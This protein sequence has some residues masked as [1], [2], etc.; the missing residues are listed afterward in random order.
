MTLAGAGAAGAAAGP[1]PLG[2]ANPFTGTKASQPDFGT[3]GAAG[4]TFPGAVV[5]F[6]ALAWSPDTH[7]SRGNFAAG[8]TYSD[9]SIEGFSLTRLSGAG[10]PQLQDFPFM[11]TREPV[12]ASPARR[13]GRGLRSRYRARFSHRSES[14]QPGTYTVV[15]DPGTRK[16]IGVE[17]TAAPHSGVARFGFAGRGPANLL[18]DA[19]GSATPN[20]LA[21]VTIDPRRREISGTTRAG[22]FCGQQN[23]YEVHFVAR[24]DHGFDSGATWRGN[25]FNRGDLSAE[26][27]GRGAQAGAYVGFGRGVGTVE[28]RV[29]IS[30]TS[31]AA[32]RANLRAEVGGKSFEPV[33][34][35]ARRAWRKALG[36]VSV[37]GGGAGAQR[38][39]ATALYH[40]LLHPSTISD[41]AGTFPRY[42]GGVGR[43]RKRDRYSQISGWDVYRT[44][45]PL[46]ALLEPRLTS[47]VVRSLLGAAEESGALPK[48]PVA[49]GHT[50]VMTGDPAD[51]IIAGA[52]AMGARDFDVGAA[53]ART[54]EGATKPLVLDGGYSQRPG[55]AE[56]QALGYVPFELNADP[57][58]AVPAPHVLAWG[59][60]AT[61]LEYALADFSISCL[62]EAAG[63]APLRARF[64]A[65]SAAWENALDPATGLMAPRRS[66]GTFAGGD[67]TSDVGFA[68]GSAAQYTWMAP[69]DLPG[70][71]AAL[72]GSAVA[73]ARLDDFLTELNTGIDSTRA[74]LGNE[75]T[76]H[77]PWIYNW[78]GRPAAAQE[79][80]RRAQRELYGAGAGGLP[81]NDDLGSLSAWYA[82][83]ALGLYPVV[84]GTDLLALSTPAF[85]RAEIRLGGGRRLTLVAPGAGRKRPY[86]SSVTLDGVPL[87][88]SWVRA[89][90]LGAD[91][92]LRYELS[93]TPTSWATGGAPPPDFAAGAPCSGTGG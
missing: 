45:I 3:G 89:G 26:D 7:P 85:A 18:I 20:T 60:A 90:E 77:T 50:N 66:S 21:G 62:A 57:I 53:L 78:L 5:P 11:P 32:A 56:Y 58:A 29:G 43:D 4:N 91:S 73:A 41:V 42:D 65:R 13:G 92:Q 69:H 17:L 2:L 6:G 59:S 34:A 82:F 74:F 31:V 63:A 24:F 1:D 86:V 54:V 9:N 22:G 87:E 44:Q 40:S 46:L 48:W 52:W 68:E 30:F 39:F 51:P 80:I 12:D 55:L 70:L 93:S 81:G 27:T 76:L 23:S 10:C 28:A 19:G 8:Y 15:L 71:I 84:P 35:A 33:R 83:S 47:D 88:R 75:P 36:A 14:A 25:D 79:A 67:P 38:T 61:T 37:R 64:L 72:G 16:Q 49:A